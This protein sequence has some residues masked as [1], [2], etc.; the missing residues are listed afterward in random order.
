MATFLYNI[1]EIHSNQM[2]VQKEYMIHIDRTEI[3]DVLTDITQ[4]ASFHPLIIST[5]K[6]K[7]SENENPKF[8][9]LERP[10]YFIPKKV[11]YFAEVITGENFIEYKISG[12]P[13]V[14]PKITYQLD[15]LKQK[16]SILIF[17]IEIKG[18]FIKRLLS[19]LMVKSQDKLISNVNESIAKE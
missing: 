9:I 11:K 4:Y 2:R 5:K 18:I 6:I 8:Q 14:K 15:Q 13:F 17:K 10:Y 7:N 16:P 19:N 1:C 12:I 3:I